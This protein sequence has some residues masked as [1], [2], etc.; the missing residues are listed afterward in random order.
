MPKHSMSSASLPLFDQS[1][2]PVI[3]WVRVVGGDQ[4]QFFSELPSPGRLLCLIKVNGISL[5]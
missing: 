2:Y 1:W 4:Q 5:G 3:V